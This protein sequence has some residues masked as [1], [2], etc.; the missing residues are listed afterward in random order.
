MAALDKIAAVPERS[1]APQKRPF[2]HARP[3]ANNETLRS[4]R[5][6]SK[7]RWY[8]EI[9]DRHKTVASPVFPAMKALAIHSIV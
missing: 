6:R 5:S 2:V 9:G 4:V 1:R 3:A 7:P 8:D